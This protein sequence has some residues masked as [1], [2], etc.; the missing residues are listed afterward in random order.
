[1]IRDPTAVR[2]RIEAITQEAET[3]NADLKHQF[4]ELETS[5]RSQ[6]ARRHSSIELEGNVNL[7]IGEHK[8]SRVTRAT[9]SYD[10]VLSLFQAVCGGSSTHMGYKTTGDRFI[11][12]RNAFDIK[13]LFTL[14]MGEQLNSLELVPLPPD[15]VAPIEK[16]NLRKENTYRQRDPAFFL[17]CTGPDGALIWLSFPAAQ[18]LDAATQALK[19]IFGEF[20]ALSFVD[21]EGDK[22]VIDGTDAWD[23]AIATATRTAPLGRYPMLV[24]AIAPGE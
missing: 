18:P 13:F 6:A 4:A 7:K 10:S 20:T 15:L 9:A 16:F 14:Y 19:Q 24:V 2:E 1:M 5:G 3:R 17:D 12:I 23:Y 11:W 22:I 21:D 8:A